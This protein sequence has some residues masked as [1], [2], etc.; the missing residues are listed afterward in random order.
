MSQSV[1]GSTVGMQWAPW[2]TRGVSGTLIG[3]CGKV[4]MR[5]PTLIV[6]K[7]PLCYVIACSL[8]VVREG[9]ETATLS[10][11]RESPVGSRM[12]EPWVATSWSIVVRSAVFP[13]PGSRYDAIHLEQFP[14][15]HN[16]KGPQ[17]LS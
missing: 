6:A 3:P 5:C 13:R 7:R 4:A 12:A 1:P 8:L 15:R 16:A 14:E 17:V 10:L 2:S 9:G 11:V